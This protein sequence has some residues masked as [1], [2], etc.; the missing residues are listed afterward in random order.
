MDSFRRYLFIFLFAMAVGGLVSAQNNCVA[1]GGTVYGWNPGDAWLAT[2]NFYIDGKP[3]RISLVDI[4]T[5]FAD[6]GD[7][8]TGTEAV[9]IDFGKGDKLLMSA[10]FVAE[11]MNDA[12]SSSGVFHI[13]EIGTFTKGSGRFKNA[14]GHWTM[15]GPFGPAVPLPIAPL[16]AANTYWIGQY[17]GMLC[18]IK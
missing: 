1:F 11:H 6:G 12:A 18:G 13:N 8:W 9:T 15:Q 17:D 5:S 14:Y 16:P 3:Y 4:N 10:E 7:V 2:G